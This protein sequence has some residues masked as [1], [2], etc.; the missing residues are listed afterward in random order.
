M[1]N[2]PSVMLGMTMLVTPSWF[3]RTC[4]DSGERQQTCHVRGEGGTLE[5]PCQSMAKRAIISRS[6]KLTM[7]QPPLLWWGIP[8]TREGSPSAV[9]PC[10]AHRPTD[11]AKQPGPLA[12]TLKPGKPGWR[13]QSASAAG[14]AASR[15]AVFDS[16]PIVGL[17]DGSHGR[18]HLRPVQDR[19]RLLV[20]GWQRNVP[21]GHKGRDSREKLLP[22]PLG[23]WDAAPLPSPNPHDEQEG[24]PTLRSRLHPSASTS[25]SLG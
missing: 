6:P 9:T 17:P 19:W 15:R 16:Q 25:A 5:N 2:T 14:S 4:G 12:R 7:S 22:T 24:E 18:R 21:G 8:P 1:P 10:I 20:P 13:P 3:W 11:Q 23:I